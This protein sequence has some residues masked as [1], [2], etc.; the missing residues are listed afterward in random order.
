MPLVFITPP[1]PPE[2]PELGSIIHRFKC[3][4]ITQVFQTSD[5]STPVTGNGDPI[6]RINN[7]G[8]DG[9]PLLEG[10]GANQAVWDTALGGILWGNDKDLSAEI[11]SGAAG[12]SISVA[13][14]GA[15]NNLA[16]NV[17]PV[18]WMWA[19]ITSTAIWHGYAGGAPSSI[20]MYLAGTALIN[21]TN[22]DH[23]LLSQAGTSKE[24]SQIAW[25]S[26]DV[27]LTGSLSQNRP[28]DS[29]EMVLGART[30]V[31]GNGFR[32]VMGEVIFWDNYELTDAD[33]AQIAIYDTANYGTIWT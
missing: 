31:G 33:V 2:L 20:R 27:K 14:L 23:G 7:L 32:G 4:D 30:S 26:N 3:M 11:D 6:A 25:F 9:T 8:S 12:P 24:G 22:P 15:F 16:Q 18:L 5:E 13:V 10:T 29:E 28:G 1:P 21:S 17:N 19:D